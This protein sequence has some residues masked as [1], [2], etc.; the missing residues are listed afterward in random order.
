MLE[1]V[2]GGGGGSTGGGDLGR[3]VDALKK[4]QGQIKALLADLEG[5]EAGKAKVAAQ[6]VSRTSF[7]GGNT[8]FGEAEGFYLQ[9]NR[10]HKALVSLSKSLGDQIEMLSIAVHG[11]DVGFN[12]LEEEQRRRF[13]SIQTRVLQ[14]QQ[15][16]EKQQARWEAQ[17]KQDKEPGE[18]GGE[19]EPSRD[20]KKTINPKG[21]G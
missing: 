4:F 5:G 13:Y 19:P 14:E 10:V 8:E 21:L 12:N 16:Q 18:K 17:Q 1:A 11:A 15:E 3:G 2:G 9:Y 20:D 7:S 6:A